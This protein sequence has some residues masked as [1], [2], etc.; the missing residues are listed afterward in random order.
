MAYNLEDQAIGVCSDF[1][2]EDNIL[3]YTGT[4]D[5]CTFIKIFSTA[6]SAKLLDYAR[7]KIANN[8][9]IRARFIGDVNGGAGDGTGL[10]AYTSYTD[11]EVTNN[12]CDGKD[13]TWGCVQWVRGIWNNLKYTNNIITGYTNNSIYTGY[14]GKIVGYIEDKNLIFG[15]GNNVRQFDASGGGVAPTGVSGTNLSSATTRAAT[16][17]DASTNDF[18]L[19]AGSLAIDAGVA[20][21]LTTDYAGTARTGANDV[22]AYAYV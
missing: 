16:F 6:T 5:K 2:I 18:H 9:C 7:F 8:I 19:K 11:W 3:T 12:T 17:V 4:A 1:E 14:S 22:G 13:V 20:N 10:N 21:T 15:N